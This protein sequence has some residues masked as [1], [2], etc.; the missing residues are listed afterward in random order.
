MD[1]SNKLLEVI[2]ND[3]VSM[4]EEIRSGNAELGKIL[5]VLNGQFAFTKELANDNSLRAE[6]ERLQQIELQQEEARGAQGLSPAIQKMEESSEGFFKNMGRGILGGLR[7]PSFGS[8]LRGGLLTAIG[9]KFGDQIGEF[10]SVEL[11]TILSAAGFDKDITDAFTQQVKEYTGPVLMGAGIGSLFG[12]GGA[13]IGA[14]AGYLYKWLGMDKL[15]ADLAKASSKEE[16]EKLWKEFGNKVLEKLAENPVPALLLAGSLFGVKGILVA[17]VAGYLYESLG[18]ERLFNSEG[19]EEFANDIYNA[20]MNKVWGRPIP[21]ADDSAFVG[22]PEPKQAGAAVGAAGRPVLPKQAGE[23][24]SFT[25]AVRNTFDFSDGSNEKPDA[26]GGENSFLTDQALE[27]AQFT[28]RR[29][30][31]ARV[32]RDAPRSRFGLPTTTRTTTTVERAAREGA[33]QV[34]EE[35]TERAIRETIDRRGRRQFRDAVTGAYVSKETA[36]E[37]LDRGGREAAEKAAMEVAETVTTTVIKTQLKR[38]PFFLGLGFSVPFAIGRMRE[39][40]Y[41]GAGLELLE[42][43][44]AA[45]PGYGTA[46]SYAVAGGSLARDISRELGGTGMVEPAVGTN[47]LAPFAADLQRASTINA[48]GG[49]TTIINNSTTNTSGGGSGATNIP[50]AKV[51]DGYIA[52]R[53]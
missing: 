21:G 3:Q 25:D 47:Q 49:D 41:V 43:L 5:N 52:D 39:G 6:T 27:A 30:L 36:Q 28:T 22:P 9:Y 50:A 37:I 34:A 51:S 35:G 40:D 29:R 38:L 8:V 44:T 53:I 46:A 23:K 42:G 33:E 31:L 18:L 13:L 10:L 11:D 20:V 16:K 19:R 17:G 48:R 24:T 2:H 15:Y 26:T 1:S 4:K 32:N 7:I 14:I 12:P 45:I